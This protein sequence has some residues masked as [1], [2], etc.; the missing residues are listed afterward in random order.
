MKKFLFLFLLFSIIY[1][2]DYVY[3]LPKDGNIA[4]KHIINLI[5]HAHKT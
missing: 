4:Q 5:T 1:A 3:F 2:R